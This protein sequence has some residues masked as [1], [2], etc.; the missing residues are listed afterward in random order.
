MCAGR[1]IS[2]PASVLETASLPPHSLPS[3]LVA[4]LLEPVHAKPYLEPAI[5]PIGKAVD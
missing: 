5:D 1:K 3:E 4:C 2:Y